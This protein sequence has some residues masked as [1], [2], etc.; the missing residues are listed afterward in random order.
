MIGKTNIGNNGLLLKNQ[1]L[2]YLSATTGSTIQCFKDDILVTT[3]LS[4][5]GLI[6]NPDNEHSVWYYII[7]QE[8][9]G[10][11]TFIA[12]LGSVSNEKVII[13]NSKGEYRVRLGIKILYDTGTYGVGWS[14]TTLSY[15]NTNYGALAPT[16]S[17]QDSYVNIYDTVTFKYGAYITTSKID[18]APYQRLVAYCHKLYN[19]ANGRALVTINSKFSGNNSPPYKSTDISTSSTPQLYTL[20][21]EDIGYPLYVGFQAQHNATTSGYGYYIRMHY[22]ALLE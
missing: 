5:E 9:F 15:D 3:L 13:V 20:Y 12:T 1:A 7:E 4:T 10:T 18:L 2:I 17:N 14:A 21:I 6:E 22:Y 16:I 11:W 8:N 19:I